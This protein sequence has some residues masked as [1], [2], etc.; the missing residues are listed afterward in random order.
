MRRICH[1]ARLGL[2]FAVNE[3]D[4]SLT[5][6]A[7][8]ASLVFLV[9]P[10]FSQSDLFCLFS[11]DKYNKVVEPKTIGKSPPKI[12]PTLSPPAP[13][14]GKSPTNVPQPPISPPLNPETTSTPTPGPVT[15][16][17]DTAPPVSEPGNIGR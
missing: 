11:P 10:T 14:I 4:N 12:P 1:Y 6:Y 5:A 9:L 16:K 13:P 17:T 7:I 2:A 8:Q 15:P 3:R